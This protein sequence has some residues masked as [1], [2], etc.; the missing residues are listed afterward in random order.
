[1]IGTVELG[2]EG[3]AT[4]PVEASNGRE[5]SV[6]LT[7]GADNESTGT[8]AVLPDTLAPAAPTVEVAEDGLSLIISGEPNTTANIINAAGDVIGTVELGEEGTATFP[9]EA[10]NGRKSLSR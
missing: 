8:P 2:E 3:T 6:T 7:D 1:M 5:V 4:F 9:V 10:S